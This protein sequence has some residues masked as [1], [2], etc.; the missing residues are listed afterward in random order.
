[1]TKVFKSDP[2]KEEKQRRA[3]FLVTLFAIEA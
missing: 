3:T 2:L 1:M